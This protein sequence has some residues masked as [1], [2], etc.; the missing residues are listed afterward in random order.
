MIYHLPTSIQHL[1]STDGEMPN[2]EESK[3]AARLEV[4]EVFRRSPRRVSFS[5]L[6]KPT[7]IRLFP[8]Q[9][10]TAPACKLPLWHGQTADFI[11]FR[12]NRTLLKLW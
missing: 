12:L 4:Q 5:I 11:L 6:F 9:V 7:D 1:R 3:V 2:E 10:A 8:P